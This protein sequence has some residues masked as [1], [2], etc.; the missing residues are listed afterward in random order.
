MDRY[1]LQDMI[2]HIE[3][4]EATHDAKFQGNEAHRNCLPRF[5]IVIAKL[6]GELDMLASIE[7][8]VTARGDE[9]KPAQKLYALAADL[10]SQ[11]QREMATKFRNKARSMVAKELNELDG[12]DR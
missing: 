9:L 8:K 1:Y 10:E 4:E 6:R 2:A 11:A 5:D 12:F 7:A 3:Q